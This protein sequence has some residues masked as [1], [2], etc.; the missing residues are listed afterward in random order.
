MRTFLMILGILLLAAAAGCLF[1]SLLNFWGYMRLM[2]GSPAMYD[3]LM[4]GAKVFG[5]GAAVCGLLG[6]L[7]LFLR[8]RLGLSP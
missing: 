4:S 1:M 8:K 6:G 7:C 5:I 3:N 2:D